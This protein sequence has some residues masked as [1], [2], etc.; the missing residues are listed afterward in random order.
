MRRRT[1][2]DGET[3]GRIKEGWGD[4]GE[5]KKGIGEGKKG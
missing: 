3:R 2:K 5:N 4:K 1:E